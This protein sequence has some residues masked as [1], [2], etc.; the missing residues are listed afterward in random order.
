MI[1]IVSFIAETIADDGNPLNKTYT[2][3]MESWVDPDTAPE[4]RMSEL[5]NSFSDPPPGIT[6]IEAK[7]THVE[8]P[9]ED[10]IVNIQVMMSLEN[11]IR[12]SVEYDIDPYEILESVRDNAGQD[13]AIAAYHFMKD[14]N[15]QLRTARISNTNNGLEFDNWPSLPN[16]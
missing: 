5:A 10:G 7:I 15:S 3:D 14:P 11:F 8:E 6:P 4:L 12:N 2:F 13:A 16:L 1:D 9:D